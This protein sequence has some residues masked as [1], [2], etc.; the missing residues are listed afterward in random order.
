MWYIGVPSNKEDS[1][2]RIPLDRAA[3]HPLYQQI[4]AFLRQGIVSGIL[5]AGTRLP[6]V[7]R[8]AVDLQVNRIT[9]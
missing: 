4:E 3:G 8:M 1:T 2:M 5:P 6:A 9:V 7:R